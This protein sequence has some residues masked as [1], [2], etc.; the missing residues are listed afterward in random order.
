MTLS[1]YSVLVAKYDREFSTCTTNLMLAMRM[2]LIARYCV[3]CGYWCFLN[4][5]ISLTTKFFLVKV[6]G[7]SCFVLVLVSEVNF[8]PEF[9]VRR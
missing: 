1:G 3:S 2:M 8:V 5:G 4:F 6:L 7:V 9:G